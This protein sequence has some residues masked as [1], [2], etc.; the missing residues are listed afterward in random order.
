MEGRINSFYKNCFS[1]I[2]FCFRVDRSQKIGEWVEVRV[3]RCSVEILVGTTVTWEIN[4]SK[5]GAEVE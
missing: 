4:W 2:S 3:L 1:L 5:G